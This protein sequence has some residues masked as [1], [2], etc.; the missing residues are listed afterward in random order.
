MSQT[1]RQSLPNPEPLPFTIDSALLRE[2]GERLVGRSH[3]ALAELI[4]NAYD[5]DATLV[6]VVFA[7]DTIVV[8][9]N[10]HGMTYEEFRDLWM[11]IGS[12]HKERQE[13]SRTLKRPLTG[14]KGVGR[15]AAQFLAH[16]LQLRTVSKGSDREVY[17]LVNWD[18]AV[19]AG[20]LT[21]ATALV[22][23]VDADTSFPGGA[24]NG[25]WVRMDRLN[26]EWGSVELEDLARELWPLQ[27][28]FDNPVL[29]GA[30][31]EEARRTRARPLQAQTHRAWRLCWRSSTR[32]RRAAAVAPQEA[33][34]SA[35]EPATRPP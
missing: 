32:R 16:E 1:V 11:R 34:K 6:D 13:R 35:C 26:G 24:V 28:P 10:G 25:T 12:T 3:I 30:A 14:S 5:A 18:E 21:R 7:D 8:R 17:A 23:V 4:K 20:E 2:L 22:D 15:L 29:G 31:S 19:E 33:F 27:P 9:D